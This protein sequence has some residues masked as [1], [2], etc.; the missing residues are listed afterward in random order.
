MNKEIAERKMN[1]RY[2]YLIYLC[3]VTLV[4]TVVSFSRYSTTVEGGDLAAVAAPVIDYIPVSAQFN[5]DAIDII[6]EGIVLSGLEPGDELIYVFDISNNDGT[7]QNQVLL[8]YKIAVTFDPDPKTIPLT[9]TIT[10]AMEYQGTG[11]WTF[12]G[13]DGL[14]THSYTLTVLWSGE[15]DDMSYFDKE[16]QIEITINTEQARASE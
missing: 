4:M 11:E 3:V 7:R 13:F 16:Q 15:E 1:R 9:Y 8:K 2:V 12:L 14:E 5:G 10:P 6:G